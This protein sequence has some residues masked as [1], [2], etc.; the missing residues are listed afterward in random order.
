MHIYLVMRFRH[1]KELSTKPNSK[2]D[3]LL[4][5]IAGG[6]EGLPPQM[7]E[8]IM[9]LNF[10]AEMK[11]AN[12]KYRRDDGKELFMRAIIAFMVSGT[13]RSF[14]A[15][16]QN[17][18]RQRIVCFQAHE[19]D[20]SKRKGVVFGLHHSKATQDDSSEFLIL[21]HVKPL[22]CALLSLAIYMC[23]L[24][25]TG[26]APCV[27]YGDESAVDFAKVRQGFHSHL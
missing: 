7:L 3:S 12:P 6:E 4:K 13:L 10:F 23:H 26:K 24:D 21:P 1:I 16:Q 2:R 22:M 27:D 11:D 18:L 20:W 17:V 8:S 15:L 25:I 9:S 5:F 19:G 14:N